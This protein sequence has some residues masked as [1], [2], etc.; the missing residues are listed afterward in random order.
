[1]PEQY[2]EAALLGLIEGLT[3]FLPVSSTGHLILLVDLLGFVGP[4][5]KVFEVVIQLGAILA[6]CLIYFGRLWRV[7][8]GLTSSRASWRFVTAILVAFLPSAALGV[9]LHGFIKGVLFNPTVVCVA[10]I[11]GG[12]AIILVERALPRPR[13]FEIEAFSPGLALRIGLFQCLALVPGVSRSG[14]TILGSLLMGVDRRTAAEFSFFLAIPTMLGATV[15][16]LYK[17]WSVM[18]LDAGALIAVGFV[19]AFVAALIVVKTLLDFVSRYG[20]TPFGWYRI[21]VG[22]VMLAVLY[23]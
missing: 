2:L 6:I 13:H 8:V 22:V 5:G 12:L 17:N 9:L 23:L 7:A 11:V 4:P 18:N 20:F 16:D 15:Y 1:M 21:A 10:L 19:C 3:E 14:A